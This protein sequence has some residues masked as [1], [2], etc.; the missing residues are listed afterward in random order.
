MNFEDQED[1]IPEVM[2]D[3][4]PLPEIEDA[5]DML[6]EDIELPPVLVEGVLHAGSK[7]VIGGSSKSFK[8]WTLLDLAVSV[9]TGEDWWGKKTTP[10]RVLYVNLEIG[11]PHF[12]KRLQEILAK[13]GLRLEKGETD[14]WNLRGYAAD[15]TDLKPEILRRVKDRNYSL[16][17]LDPIYKCLGNRD[18]NKAGDIA[19][20]MNDIEAIAVASGAAV[21]FGAHFSKGNQSAKESMDRIGGSGVFARDPDTILVMT[22]HEQDDAFVVEATLRNF[23]PMPA[24]CVK[25]EAPLMR[26]APELNPEDLKQAGKKSI[27][28]DDDQFVGLFPPVRYPK[29]PR[30][31]LLSNA[32]LTSVFSQMGFDKNHLVDCRDKAESAGKIGVIR[33]LAHNQILAG[34]PEVVAAFRE[35]QEKRK[36]SKKNGGEK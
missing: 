3:G 2:N 24:F 20:L 33:G 4:R 21:A 27:V 34:L 36:S 35:T 32:E 26:L 12:Q 7:M 5:F 8:T 29:E 22:R 18:E 17:I 31:D 6:A 14:I 1:N 15:L 23:P 13:R 10:G 28:P 30:K 25:W 11:K 9:A 16:I 19:T